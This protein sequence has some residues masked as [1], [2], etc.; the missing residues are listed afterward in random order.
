[1]AT[2][3]NPRY[4]Y[5]QKTSEHWWLQ[6]SIPDSLVSHYG[7]K[8]LQRSTRTASRTTSIK[9]RNEL[10]REIELKNAQILER[11][12]SPS[13]AFTVAVDRY[14]RYEEGELDEAL[15]AYQAEHDLEDSNH[16]T[17]PATRHPDY[18]ALLHHLT[19]RE[20]PREL[21]TRLSDVCGELVKRRTGEVD[22]PLSASSVE[23]YSKAVNKF[24]D[25]TPIKDITIRQVDDWLQESTGSH[26]TISGYLG[27][28]GRIYEHGIRRGYVVAP[29]PFRGHTVTNRKPSEPWDAMTPELFNKILDCSPKS[30]HDFWIVMLHTGCRSAEVDSLKTEKI[31][32]ID[33]YRVTKSKTE[34]GK[35]VIP[36]HSRL[37][38]INLDHLPKAS[39]VKAFI[40]TA[41]KRG[42]LKLPPRI[43]LH[44]CRVTFTTNLLEANV[45]ERTVSSL[46]GHKQK[47]QTLAYDRSTIAQRQA[48][49]DSFAFE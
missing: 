2:H 36:L 46:V 49:V 27:C 34:S 29:N 43:G 35:R 15:I 20:T 24:G 19:G 40:Q 25:D 26:S 33:C 17:D 32:G 38:N 16:V 28:L 31:E 11:T 10:L 1:M 48:A 37:S 41:K 3:K 14:H 8:R 39:T 9:I 22:Q 4:L 23:S 47:T 42:K 5:K 6:I 45:P 30:H 12:E 7:T 44:S 21:S 18:F 13:R